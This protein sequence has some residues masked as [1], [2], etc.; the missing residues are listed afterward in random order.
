M[1]EPSGSQKAIFI[2]DDWSDYLAVK[3]QVLYVFAAPEQMDVPIS[4]PYSG[5]S[6]QALDEFMIPLIWRLMG[7]SYDVK[8]GQGQQQLLLFRACAMSP[9]SLV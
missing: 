6:I 4:P 9:Y 1:V 7:G 3:V 8:K 2:L 5:A